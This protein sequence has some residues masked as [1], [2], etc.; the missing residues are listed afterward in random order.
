MCSVWVVDCGAYENNGICAI[1]LTREDAETA[2]IA[3]G[4]E[5]PEREGGEWLTAEE[6]AAHRAGRYVSM[7]AGH[8]LTE[9]QLD[10]KIHG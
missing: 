3:A 8:G 10:G 2:L 6:N 9:Y 1:Y 5:R 7:D 4:Y